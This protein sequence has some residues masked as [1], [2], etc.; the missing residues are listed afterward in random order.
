MKAVVVLALA[1]CEDRLEGLCETVPMYEYTYDLGC[2][3]LEYCCTGEV[4]DSPTCWIEVGDLTQHVC[5][6][7]DCDDAWTAAVCEACDHAID[8]TTEDY[9]G[10]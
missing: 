2:H 8:R 4:D 10:C 5:D 1:A 7:D 6:G 9:V 3:D